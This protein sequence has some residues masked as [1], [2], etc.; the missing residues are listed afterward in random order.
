M[1]YLIL[2]PVVVEADPA[3]FGGAA[4]KGFEAIA[5][6]FN[7]PSEMT[8]HLVPLDDGEEAKAACKVL[9]CTFK[10]TTTPQFS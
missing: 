6:Y 8:V 9:N 10:A 7:E 4:R 3:D 5:D 1:K 2:L